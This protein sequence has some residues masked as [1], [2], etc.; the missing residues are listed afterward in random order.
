MATNLNKII[1]IALFATLAFL[2]IRPYITAIVF[3][4]VVAYLL[5]PAHL[6]ISK[7]VSERAS[8]YLL[9]FAAAAAIILL[10]S[11]GASLL[12]NEISKIYIFI[13]KI[14]LQVS[15]LELGETVKNLSRTMISKIIEGLSGAITSIPKILLSFFVFFISLFYFLKDGQKIA[16]LL[17]TSLPVS[18]E[19]KKAIFSDMQRYTRAFVYVWAIIAF[20]QGI[21]AVVGFYLF[22]LSYVL[23]AGLAAATLSFL[24][25]IGPYALYVPIGAL[26][27][28]SGRPD[29]GIGILVYGLT[30]GSILDYV[31]RPYL[32]GKQ[33]QSH[34]LLV[35]LGILGG[36]SL[37]GPAGIIVG[38][39]ILLAAAATLKSVKLGAL[40]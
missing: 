8:L 37:I 21:V 1:I 33:S 27:I 26:L 31:V 13:S 6:K 4:A 9:T 40:K 32:A 22:G 12:L 39:I 11:F 35:L 2:I 29:T 10:I 17:R 30:I 23:L 18:E 19:K 3:A 5:Y 36:L 38:P 16:G 20:A 24:P 15:G 7:S 28:L 34:P 14:N 25:I